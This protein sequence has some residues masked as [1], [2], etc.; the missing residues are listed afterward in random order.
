MRL[1]DVLPLIERD[2]MADE[3]MV[4]YLGN[5]LMELDLAGHPSK[6][7]SMRSCRRSAWPIPTPTPFC[8]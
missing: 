8:L 5:C 7:C 3:D 2:D 1:D 6:R 4:A